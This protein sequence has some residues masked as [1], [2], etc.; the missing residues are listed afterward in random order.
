VYFQDRTSLI[1]RPLAS[2]EMNTS[3]LDWS[4]EISAFRDNLYMFRE[5]GTYDMFGGR[6]QTNICSLLRCLELRRGQTFSICVGFERTNLGIRIVMKNMYFRT[7]FI[8]APEAQEPSQMH[9]H[10]SV[11]CHQV[12]PYLNHALRIR[13]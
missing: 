8:S 1:L 10:V 13:T 3:L 4:G 12:L 5:D 9:R 7:S 11:P 6:G 2:F